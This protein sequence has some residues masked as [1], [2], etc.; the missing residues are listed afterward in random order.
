MLQ[1]MLEFFKN[2]ILTEMKCYWK[3]TCEIF[4]YQIMEFFELKDFLT[5]DFKHT[6]YL[7]YMWF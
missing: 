7:F 3:S 6:L 5:E 2:V 1:Q 4:Q